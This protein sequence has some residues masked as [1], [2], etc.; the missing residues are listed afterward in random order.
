MKMKKYRCEY[1]HHLSTA[2]M[3]ECDVGEYVKIE[4][5]EKME[6]QLNI[7]LDRIRDLLM[8]EDGHAQKEAEKF[9]EQFKQ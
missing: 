2:E 9:L 4:D 6:R 7:T 8:P 3:V 5:A 1:F